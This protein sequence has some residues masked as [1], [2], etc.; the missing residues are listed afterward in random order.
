MPP[1]M[2]DGMGWGNFGLLWR[3]RRCFRLEAQQ[4]LALR[5]YGGGVSGDGAHESLLHPYL[6]ALTSREIKRRW[7][8]VRHLVVTD[9]LGDGHAEQCP[10]DVIHQ[11]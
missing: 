7:E 4:W 8:P 5:A 3:L 11:E 2:L 9:F 1:K 6:D 10:I